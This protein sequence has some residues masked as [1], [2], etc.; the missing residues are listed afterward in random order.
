MTISPRLG[1]SGS[2]AISPTGDKHL[3][4]LLT[5]VEDVSSVEGSILRL[6]LDELSSEELVLSSGGSVFG[7]TILTFPK[8]SSV[9]IIKRL[10]G[11]GIGGFLKSLTS[12]LPFS[13][14]YARL[15]RWSRCE[16]MTKSDQVDG[17]CIASLIG[18]SF[19]KRSQTPPSPRGL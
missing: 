16:K 7:A 5:L 8:S 18:T 15:A 12:L 4:S 11:G 9:L 1:P 17:S 3:G 14:M 19:C 6:M 13:T 10:G 2:L